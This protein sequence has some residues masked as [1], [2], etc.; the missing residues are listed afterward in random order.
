MV[1]AFL[2]VVPRTIPSEAP[3]NGILD[4]VN[5]FLSVLFARRGGFGA[6]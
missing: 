6:D 2:V 1:A 5:H 3:A 4:D